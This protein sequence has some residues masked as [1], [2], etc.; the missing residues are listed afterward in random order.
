MDGMESQKSCCAWETK[1]GSRPV[2][3][4]ITTIAVV[5]SVCSYFFEE[6][7]PRNCIVVLKQPCN[8]LDKINVDGAADE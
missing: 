3:S 4:Q 8:G 1:A 5:V 7:K 2:F 6:M